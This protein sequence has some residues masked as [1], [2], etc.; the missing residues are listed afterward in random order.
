MPSSSPSRANSSRCLISSQLVRLP[1]FAIVLHPH[2][3]PAAVQTFPIQREFQIAL[4]QRLLGRPAFG[5]PIAAI[6]ELDGSAAILAFGNR[7]FEIAIIERMVL[8]L[9]RQA[10]VM[11]IERG[12]SRHRPG[13]EHA[14]E[15][16]PKIVMEPRRIVLLDHEA[17]PIRRPAFWIAPLGSAVFAK[18]RLA[19]YFESLE[20]S[21]T[22]SSMI[23]A[24]ECLEK[25][26]L[27]SLVP[28]VDCGH[29]LGSRG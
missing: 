11:R 17:R 16:E 20:L 27:G 23:N 13:L 10:L 8:D 26:I 3:H 9:D 18:S 24:E 29:E 25:R 12:P 4:G 21:A 14:V 5:L 19:R 1:P 2:Q 7:A 22:R 15:F 6:P 28:V